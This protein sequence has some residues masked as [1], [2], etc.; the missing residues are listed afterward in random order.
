MPAAKKTLFVTLTLK[1]R[2]TVPRFSACDGIAFVAK[3]H[4]VTT[5]RRLD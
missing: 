4:F 3:R 5:T 2:A 1:E